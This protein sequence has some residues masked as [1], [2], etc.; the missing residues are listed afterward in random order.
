MLECRPK[1]AA[2]NCL[3]S[4]YQQIWIIGCKLAA[5]FFPSQG[6]HHLHTYFFSRAVLYTH[7]TFVYHDFRH[8]AYLKTSEMLELE[9]DL[10]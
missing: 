4:L 8:I 10:L 3:Q 2:A 1:M 5:C 9:K 7:S 6:L